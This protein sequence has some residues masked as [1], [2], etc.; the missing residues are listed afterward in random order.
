MKKATPKLIIAVPLLVLLGNTSQAFESNRIAVETLGSG[1]ALLFIPGL[2][3]SPDVWNGVLE[4]LDASSVH[5][6][7]VRGFGGLR[8]DGNAAGDILPNL[9]EEIAR[10]IEE[11]ELDDVTVVAHSMGGLVGTMVAARHPDMVDRLMILDIPAYFGD[12]MGLPP[13][14][15]K[16]VAANLRSEAL[17]RTAEERE[18]AEVAFI[19]AGVLDDA[20]RPTVILDMLTSDA[21]VG[22]QAQ[23]EVMITDLRPELADI[24]A[25]TMV[26]FVQPAQAPDM[27]PEA[28][29]EFYASQYG[30]IPDVEFRFIAESGHF[31]ML[32][33]PER[34]TELIQELLR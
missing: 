11:E 29:T 9:A 20:K 16:A 22:A 4:Q 28:V 8:A 24:A 3:S 23:Y 7:H 21:A 12:I 2:N 14:Q 32:D 1:P 18:A 6:V 13:D 31:V 25:E 5:L 33:Q 15:V 17:A 30:T 27:T 19:G 26:V 34:V 10:Y